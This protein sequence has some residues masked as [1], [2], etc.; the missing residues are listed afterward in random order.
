MVGQHQRL[1]GTMGDRGWQWMVELPREHREV[2]AGWLFAGDVV[3]SEEDELQ[4]ATDYG[5]VQ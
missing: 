3:L 2:L 4:D 1:M 5:S